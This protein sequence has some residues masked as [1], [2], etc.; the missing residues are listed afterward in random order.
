MPQKRNVIYRRKRDE[1]CVARYRLHTSGGSIQ[2]G[3]P[4]AGGALG[5]IQLRLAIDPRYLLGYTANHL[6]Y[7][8]NSIQER[9]YGRRLN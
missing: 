1:D 7:S 6:A 4:D 5:F 8:F 3:L 9:S 2:R